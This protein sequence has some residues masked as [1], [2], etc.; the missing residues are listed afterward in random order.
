MSEE[1]KLQVEGGKFTTVVEGQ[2]CMA[3]VSDEAYFAEPEVVR[4]EEG[5]IEKVIFPAEIS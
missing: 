2:T 5:K 3:E 4:D 1:I